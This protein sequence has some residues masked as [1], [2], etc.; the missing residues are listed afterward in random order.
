MRWPEADPIADITTGT[1][2]HSFIASK[3]SDFGV[4]LS[5]T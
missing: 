3:V 2:A 5:F 4:P 1:I